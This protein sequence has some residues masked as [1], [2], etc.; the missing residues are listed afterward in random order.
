MA[1]TKADNNR[2]A[3]RYV[4]DDGNNYAISA[5]VVYALD[6]TD[7]AKYGAA[8]A[9]A[10]DLRI[11]KDMKPRKIKCVAADKPDKWVVCYTTTAAAWTT[12]GT[13]LTLD[14]NGVDVAYTTQAV[15]R[16]EKRRDTTRQSA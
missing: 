2:C 6:V 4:S 13:T 7:G 12:P 8:A 15:K 9:Q 16:P 5:K 14:C 11:P 10:A 3:I 1:S